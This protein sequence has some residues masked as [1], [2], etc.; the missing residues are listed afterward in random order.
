M[1]SALTHHV[2][3]HVGAL[4][5]LQQEGRCREAQIAEDRSKQK[6]L[7]GDADAALPRR[8]LNPHRA[9]ITIIAREL[10][11]ELDLGHLFERYCRARHCRP[12]TCRARRKLLSPQRKSMHKRE[13]LCFGLVIFIR[14]PRSSKR[15]AASNIVCCARGGAC[16]LAMLGAGA[17]FGQQPAP[18]HFDLG[19][20]K[21]SLRR[22]QPVAA[23]ALDRTPAKR[24]KPPGF[25]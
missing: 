1:L 6:G 24:N 18:K 17:E 9:E 16:R 4:L 2:L 11:P 20:L 12:R 5:F 15:L 21:L 10:E 7:P 19:L 25:D 3:P 14:T 23:V 8:I 22:N 13:K